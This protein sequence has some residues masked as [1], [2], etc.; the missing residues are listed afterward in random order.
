MAQRLGMA[1]PVRDKASLYGTAGAGV[2][3][4]E[5]PLSVSIRRF[6]PNPFRG[7]RSAV[8]PAPVLRGRRVAGEPLWRGE[9]VEIRRGG[10]ADLPAVMAM[11]DGAVAWLEAS[12]R[13]GQWG[14]RPWS[15]DP[16]RAGKIADRVRDDTVWIAE[17]DGEP[18][19]TL[20]HSP[21]APDYVPPAGEPE[22]YVRLLVTSRA[23]TGRGV[24]GAL[25]DH[26]RAQARALGVEL[27]RV[28]CYAGG[29]GRLVR[30]Y[31]RNG[32]T[33]VGT[34]EVGEWPG[35]LLSDRVG[36]TATAAQAGR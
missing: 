8:P 7:H 2:L 1:D 18:A 20:I 35:Q 27:V 12:G 30:Y 24:G 4:N 10:P 36:S 34:F 32:F 14:S 28:D 9:L 31:R 17:V 16:E 11:L 33:P 23:F 13:T 26:A 21:A 3:G 19:G 5:S 25:L 22:L 6:L 29:D 15:A